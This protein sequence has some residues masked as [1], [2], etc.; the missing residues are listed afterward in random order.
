MRRRLTWWGAHLRSVA[1]DDR[2]YAT[3]VSAGIITA[4]VALAVVVAGI[5][6][7]V[8]GSHQAQVAADLSAVA[9]ATALYTGHEPC[10]AARTTALL[11]SAQVGQCA[12]A[13]VD[14]T[15]TVSVGRAKATARAGPL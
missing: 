7:H 6:S 14:V 11:N 12:I 3:V 1:A 13:G 4:V 10:S 5:V 9:A 8:V 2:G 15:V